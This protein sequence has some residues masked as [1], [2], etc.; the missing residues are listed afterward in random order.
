MNKKDK[1]FDALVKAYST[2]IYRFAYWLCKDVA[3]AED[4]TQ[5]TFTRAWKALDSLVDPKAAKGWLITITRREIARHFSKKRIE[6]IN[7]QDVPVEQ[8]GADGDLSQHDKLII[9]EA[10]FS[11]DNE[12][13][14][15]LLLQ[16]LGGF[17]CN[18]IADMMDIKPGAVMTRLF[19][20]KQQLRQVLGPD[21]KDNV[22]VKL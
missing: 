22:M 10:I 15:P 9:H 1:E 20:A 12:Y 18:E 7:I 11:L 8:L 2:D 21:I 13:R 14:E 19:R 5:E 16:V 4:M 3:L 6:T 17:S